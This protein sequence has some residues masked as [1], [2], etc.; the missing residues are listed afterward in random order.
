MIGQRDHLCFSLRHAIENRCILIFVHFATFLMTFC[1]PK[2]SQGYYRKKSQK[3][4]FCKIYRKTSSII[5]K[6]YWKT[7]RLLTSSFVTVLFNRLFFAC[8]GLICRRVIVLVRN[9][10]LSG[11]FPGKSCPSRLRFH[12]TACRENNKKLGSRNQSHSQSIQ[13]M[14]RV[15][16]SCTT[17]TQDNCCQSAASDSKSRHQELIRAYS[18]FVIPA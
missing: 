14:R 11:D 3:S 13:P 15:P 7:F 18:L 4:R 16:E 6:S 1:I 17:K 8:T 10:I 2:S 9:F 12:T 5:G